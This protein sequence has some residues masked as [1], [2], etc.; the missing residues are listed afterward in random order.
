[1]ILFERQTAAEQRSGRTFARNAIG[2]NAP[3]APFFTRLVEKIECE[4]PLSEN[5]LRQAELRLRKYWRQIQLAEA[6]EN[7]LGIE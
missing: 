3:D 1:M 6:S 2:F 5:E 4:E 7:G